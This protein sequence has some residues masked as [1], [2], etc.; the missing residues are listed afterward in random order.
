MGGRG[1]YFPSPRRGEGWGEGERASASFGGW[2]SFADVEAPHPALSPSG[3]GL[4][5]AVTGDEQFLADRLKHALRIFQHVVV[6]EA[7]H[8]VAERVDDPR[9]RRVCFGR[10]L[11]AIEL[12]GDMRVA[13]SEVRDEAADWKLT[14]ELGSFKA[15]AP[16]MVP[17][18]VLGVGRSSSEIARD[19]SQ[20]LFGQRRTPSSQPSPRWGEG[21]C[22]HASTSR[23]ES[24]AVNA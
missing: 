18:S 8:S 20:S 4:F 5:G 17:E 7:E 16:Q 19:R 23:Y 1:T 3:R 21:V 22:R 6:P 11:T 2:R 10:M 9:A 12:D 14:D 15:A 13:T 24:F